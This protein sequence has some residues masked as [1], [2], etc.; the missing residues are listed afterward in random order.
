MQAAFCLHIVINFIL[1][2]NRINR[3]YA[4]IGKFQFHTAV[5]HIIGTRY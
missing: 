3:N 2:G 1:D 5:I 4:T